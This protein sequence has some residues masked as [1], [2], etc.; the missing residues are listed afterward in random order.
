MVKLGIPVGFRDP[1]E[2]VGQPLFGPLSLWLRRH[3][4]P[5]LFR[6]RAMLSEKHQGSFISVA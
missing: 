5:K 6:R 1:V 2:P 4:T 3:R